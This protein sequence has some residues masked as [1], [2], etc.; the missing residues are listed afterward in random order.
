MA[1]NVE[2]VAPDR[3]RWEGEAS[4]LA[5]PTVEG[6]VGILTGHQPL[7]GVLRHG[8]VRITTTGGEKIEL[9]V[10]GGF[11]SVD[12]D[13]ITVVIDSSTAGD[14]QVPAMVGETGGGRSGADGGDDQ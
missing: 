6:D 7:L 12:A 14:S 9:E 11:L 3:V 1:L 8:T 13:Q 10:D 2:V 5:A 4:A